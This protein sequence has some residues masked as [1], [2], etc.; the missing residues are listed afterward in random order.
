MFNKITTAIKFKITRDYRTKYPK[1]PHSDVALMIV[2][3]ALGMDVEYI[4][5]CNYV[6][7]GKQYVKNHNEFLKR[8]RELETKQLLELY[9]E[10]ERQLFAKCMKSPFKLF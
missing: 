9:P 1:H 3:E 5:E 10:Y 6:S 4:L 7:L 2:L 8:L